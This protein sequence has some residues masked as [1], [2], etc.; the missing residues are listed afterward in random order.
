LAVAKINSDLSTPYSL[1]L[2]PYIIPATANDRTHENGIQ[3]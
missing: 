2:S 3:M 1:L